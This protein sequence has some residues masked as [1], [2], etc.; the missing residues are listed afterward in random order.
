M[1]IIDSTQF[2]LP[3]SYPAPRDIL[4]T[5]FPS[6]KCDFPIQGRWGYGIDDAVIINRNDPAA[7]TIRF[8]NAV[9]IEYEFVSKRL[10]E[11]LIISR[12]QD[13]R[14]S[15]IEWTLKK[16]ALLSDHERK[17]DELVFIV[18]MF[19]D[20]DWDFLSNDW[21]SHGAYVNDPAGLARHEKLRETL[22]LEMEEVFLFDI[23]LC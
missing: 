5:D 10:Y 15:G 7:K 22:Q 11:E 13:K 20:K 3:S 4:L 12:E 19:A 8:F 18:T 17:Y 1:R 14:F 2:R 23:T 16:Q 21:E 6:M 9:A